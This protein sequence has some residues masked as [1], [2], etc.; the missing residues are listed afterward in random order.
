MAGDSTLKTVTAPNINHKCMSEK[1]T[2]SKG[3]KNSKSKYTNIK[4]VKKSARSKKKPLPKSIENHKQDE[5]KPT[6]EK[7]TADEIV[8][9]QALVALAGTMLAILLT[10]IAVYSIYSRQNQDRI[11][12]EVQK[13]LH[14]L[15]ESFRD[16]SAVGFGRASFL[17][18]QMN[19]LQRESWD[20]SPR[21]IFADDLSA[22]K[23]KF[24]ELNSRLKGN[25]PLPASLLEVSHLIN[26]LLTKIYCEFPSYRAIEKQKSLIEF[27]D[28]FVDVNFPEAKTHFQKWSNRVLVYHQEVL[29]VFSNLSQIILTILRTERTSYLSMREEFAGKLNLPMS[30]LLLFYSFNNQHTSLDFLNKLNIIRT[31]VAQINQEMRYHTNFQKVQPSY[32]SLLLVF[33]AVISGIVLPMWRLSGAHVPLVGGFIDAHVRVVTGLVFLISFCCGKDFV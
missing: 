15:N 25:F 20:E 21:G 4:P 29:N 13:Q 26:G 6:A 24:D 11:A 31:K 32:R 2:A 27:D 16:L 19:M 8:Y 7:R 10:F 30:E 5:A 18:N 9:L 17:V 1:M 22:I 28:E 23:K 3:D 33:F 12:V 14:S